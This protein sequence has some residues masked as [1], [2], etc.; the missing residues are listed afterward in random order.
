MCAKLPGTSAWVGWKV[1]LQGEANFFQRC[2]EVVEVRSSMP[3]DPCVTETKQRICLV[4]CLFACLH[5]FVCWNKDRMTT[6]W[7]TSA[8]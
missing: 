8:I 1:W 2:G 6:P 4:D 5:V 7:V 3:F